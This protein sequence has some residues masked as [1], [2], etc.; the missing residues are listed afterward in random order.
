MRKLV[1]TLGAALLLAACSGSSDPAPT[2]TEAPPAATTDAVET[3]P[4]EAEAPE[5][6]TAD[7]VVFAAASLNAVFPEIAEAN[8]SFDGSSGLVDQIVGGAPADVFASADQ[9]NMDRAVEEGVIDG[10]PVMFATNY[11]VIAVPAGNPAGITGFDESLD[12]TKLVICQEDVPC[13]NATRALAETQ[14]VTLTPVSEE[15]N[16]TDVLGK[17][18]SGEADAGLVYLTD[19]TGAGDKV[20]IIEIPGSDENPNT[21]WI[22]KVAGAQN[23][24]AAEA[25]IAAITGPEGAATLASFGFGPAK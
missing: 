3:E 9:E 17:V 25:F 15:A 1:A 21:Y 7:A 2:E 19:A 4:T 8:Y 10:D 5:V 23:V 14:S 20:E 6:S 13:G 18:T 16:V 24:E 22:A 12:G 11:L